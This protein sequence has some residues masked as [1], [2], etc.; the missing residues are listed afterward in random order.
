MGVSCG[1]LCPSEYFFTLLEFKLK[2]LACLLMEVFFLET[3]RTD[4]GV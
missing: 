2:C 1:E 4:L 3:V